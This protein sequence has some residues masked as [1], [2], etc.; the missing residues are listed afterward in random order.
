MNRPLWRKRAETLMVML[1]PGSIVAGPLLGDRHGRRWRG[2]MW[3]AS[4]TDAADYQ[5]VKAKKKR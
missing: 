1:P 2:S 4:P 3:M 5:R